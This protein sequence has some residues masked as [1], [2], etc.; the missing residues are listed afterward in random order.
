MFERYGAATI[1][2]T[3]DGKTKQKTGMRRTMYGKFLDNQFVKPIF[4]EQEYIQYGDSSQYQWKCMKCGNVFTAFRSESWF[5]QGQVPAYARCPTCYPDLNGTSYS[6]HDVFKYLKSLEALKP[7]MEIVSRTNEN[8]K[9]IPPYELDILI[10]K[11][12]V[13]KYAVE[14]D[15]LYWH[16]DGKCPKNYHLTKTEM[17]ERIGIRLIH[18]F[19]NDWLNKRTIVESRLNN[20]MG[21]YDKTV[22][23]RRCVVAEIEKQRADELLNTWHIQGSCQSSVNIALKDEND[24]SEVCV[25]TFGK[26]R[27]SKKHEWELLR[28]CSAKGVHIPG[29]ASKLLKYFERT[30]NPKSIVSYADRRWSN[31]NVYEKLGFDFVRNSPPNY[32]YWKIRKKTSNLE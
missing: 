14:Y 2:Q 15:G 32:W 27:F 29:G 11:D 6:E 5:K 20:L 24:G 18:I 17:C 28:F 31:G 26:S 12:G 3:A 7:G 8:R 16:S 9:L 25:M 4:S 21:I 13:V 10:K 19:E 23:A 22:F 1:S 30:Y